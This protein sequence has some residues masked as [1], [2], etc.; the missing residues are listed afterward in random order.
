MISK[1]ILGLILF[2]VAALSANAETY[3]LKVKGSPNATFEVKSV[4]ENKTYTKTVGSSVEMITVAVDKN[5][6]VTIKAIPRQ[7]Y[8][9]GVWT[10]AG[11]VTNRNE[12][13]EFR[14]DNSKSVE[15]AIIPAA[16]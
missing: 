2:V 12:T 16:N 13:I 6:R 4:Y 5:S 9:V 7:D 1:N 3:Q 14:M 11:N 10:G 8:K 15:C